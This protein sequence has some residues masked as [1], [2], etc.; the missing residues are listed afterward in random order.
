MFIEFTPEVRSNGSAFRAGKS[1]PIYD[2]RK[3]SEDFSLAGFQWPICARW[4]VDDH[5]QNRT[6]FSEVVCIENPNTPEKSTPRCGVGENFINDCMSPNPLGANQLE[7]PPEARILLEEQCG[8]R[9]SEPE[10]KADQGCAI[11]T[12]RTSARAAVVWLLAG[13]SALFRRGQRARDRRVNPAELSPRKPE[14]PR[15]RWSFS[16]G[17]RSRPSPGPSACSASGFPRPP[18]GYPAG[19]R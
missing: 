13:L 12:E 5:W 17:P 6:A 15:W 11:S 1:T 18:S 10:E 14:T 9:L 4:R 19:S 7:V 8:L 16:Q 3:L 2:W